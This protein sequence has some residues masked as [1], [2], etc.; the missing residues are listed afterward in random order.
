[1]KALL[2]CGAL[3]YAA[4]DCAA[5]PRFAIYAVT[6]EVDCQTPMSKPGSYRA[7]VPLKEMGLSAKPWV[8]DESISSFDPDS[9]TLTLR[10]GSNIRYPS[11]KVHGSAFVALVDGKRAFAGMFWTPYSS[12]CCCTLPTITTKPAETAPFAGEVVQHV[13]IEGLGES[14]DMRRVFSELGKLKH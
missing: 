7:S 8:T 1:M 11:P 5:A 12:F 6:P 10:I 9:A 2:F 13:T 14:P 4:G 3:L